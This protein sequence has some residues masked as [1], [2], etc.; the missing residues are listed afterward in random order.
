MANPADAEQF[1]YHDGDLV[2]HFVDCHKKRRVD[3]GAD[4]DNKE[5]SDSGAVGSARCYEEMTEFRQMMAMK[6]GFDDGTVSSDWADGGDGEG[7]RD[8]AEEGIGAEEAG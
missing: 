1:L 2:A 4:G 8:A 5:G 7:I 3:G 6:N